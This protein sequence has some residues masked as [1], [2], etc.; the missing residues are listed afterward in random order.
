MKTKFI[1]QADLA[2]LVADRV[3]RR[4]LLIAT[5]AA[6]GVLALGLGALAL[7]GVA[8]LWMVYGFARL[9]GVWLHS[10][11]AAASSLARAGLRAI[12]HCRRGS[13]GADLRPVDAQLL[14]ERQQA[15]RPAVARPG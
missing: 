13:H 11:G 2:G 15:R 10:S 14:H 12:G 4:T 6:Q 8:Q 3:P 9:P 7:A 1:S 5:Q